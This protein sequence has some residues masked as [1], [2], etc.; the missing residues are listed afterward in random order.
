MWAVQTEGVPYHT[1]LKSNF[2]RLLYIIFFI[3]QI[4]RVRFVSVNGRASRVKPSK[5]KFWKKVGKNF[6][7]KILKTQFWKKIR[8]KNFRKKF[9]QKKFWKN[10]LQ[11]KNFHK[12][13]YSNIDKCHSIFALLAPVDR[14]GRKTGSNENVCGIWF[15][16]GSVARS[17]WTQ[18]M[19]R[20][21]WS[22]EKRYNH[23]FRAVGNSLTTWAESASSVLRKIWVRACPHDE[24]LEHRVPQKSQ[25]L[26]ISCPTVLIQP[27]TTAFREFVKDYWLRS[28]PAEAA[29]ALWHEDINAGRIFFGQT[30]Y[31]ATH[32]ATTLLIRFELWESFTFQTCF[33]GR[34]SFLQDTSLHSH[35]ST[36]KTQHGKTLCGHNSTLHNSTRHNWIRLNST[37]HNSTRH[38]STQTTW[39]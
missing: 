35:N 3:K 9:W 23:G 29:R 22:R 7:K 4:H 10:R 37:R 39:P 28:Y 30:S 21:A 20:F 15:K 6:G 19:W 38:N 31:I 12:R 1:R 34:P 36:H 18:V 8:K 25:M 24:A 17:R 26:C 16:I 5:N 11:K 14:T 27:V 2:D 32:T 33:S 13:N